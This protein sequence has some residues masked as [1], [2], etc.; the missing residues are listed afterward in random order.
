MYAQ[1]PQALRAYGAVQAARPLREQEAEVYAILSGRLREAAASGDPLAF[2]RARADARRLF[3]A[4]QT[5]VLHESCE[6]PRELR[7]LIASVAAAALRDI[8]GGETDL[9][10]LADICDDFAAGLRARP[11]VA[12]VA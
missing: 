12:A 1:N 7:G 9:V 2:T 5:L 8:E 6:L 10:F 4:V 3:T 11:A